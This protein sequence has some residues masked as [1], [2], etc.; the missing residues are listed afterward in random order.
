MTYGP[1]QKTYR[2]RSSLA[3]EEA[4]TIVVITITI[5]IDDIL[6]VQQEYPGFH[7]STDSNYL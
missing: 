6:T 3:T 4:T 2:P 7:K 5:D 1:N